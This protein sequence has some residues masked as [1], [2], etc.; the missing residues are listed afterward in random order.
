MIDIFL[1][2]KV[3]YERNC[4]TKGAP[5]KLPLKYITCYFAK[6]S[7]L[8]EG[9]FGIKARIYEGFFLQVLQVLHK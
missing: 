5:Q 9:I 3:L 7:L 8:R 6:K 1:V 4:S 2:L